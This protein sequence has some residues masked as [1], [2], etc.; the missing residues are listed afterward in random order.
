MAV[1]VLEAARSVAPH[2]DTSGQPACE[3]LSTA[4][5]VD[6]VAVPGTMPSPRTPV[7]RAA[8]SCN[9]AVGVIA[10][11]HAFAQ[12]PN[13]AARAPAAMNIDRDATVAAAARGDFNIQQVVLTLVSALQCSQLCRRVDPGTS[14]QDR[15]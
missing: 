1:A 6:A 10:A 11:D 7:H 8:S 2:G 15:Q 9:P 14:R 13:V 4:C 5:A 12:P 3:Y